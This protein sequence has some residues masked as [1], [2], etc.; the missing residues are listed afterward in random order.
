MRLALKFEE[1]WQL[2]PG[3]KFLDLVRYNSYT[4]KKK[5]KKKTKERKK[6]KKGDGEE[7]EE[8]EEEMFQ[9]FVEKSPINCF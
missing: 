5:K 7:E 3:R 9:A 4:L 1:S 6:K 8:E 2:R